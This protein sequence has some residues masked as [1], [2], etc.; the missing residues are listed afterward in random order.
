MPLVLHSAELRWKC[1]AAHLPPPTAQLQVS[2]LSLL[3]IE[4]VWLRRAAKLAAAYQK[5]LTPRLL[6]PL[7]LG[8]MMGVYSKA[9]GERPDLLYSGSMLLGFLS[10]KVALI[11]KLVDDLTPKVSRGEWRATKLTQHCTM[12]WSSVGRV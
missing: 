2:S 4:N 5:A 11:V 8:C 3:Q 6:V 7:A 9:T 12:L 10:Y 1:M